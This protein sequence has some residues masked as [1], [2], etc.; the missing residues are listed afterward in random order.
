[1]TSVVEGE[2]EDTSSM[3]EEVEE[4]IY[5]VREEKEVPI[6]GKEATASIVVIT[7]KAGQQRVMGQQLQT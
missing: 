6:S 5:S 2:E 7:Y 1:M 4:K 3:M